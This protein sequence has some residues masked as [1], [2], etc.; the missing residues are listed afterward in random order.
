[1]SSKWF[2][3]AHA[4]QTTMRSGTGVAPRYDLAEPLLDDREQLLERARLLEPMGDA[5]K[6]LEPN[7]AGSGRR[8]ALSVLERDDVVGF[9][10]HDEQRPGELSHGGEHVD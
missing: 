5:R 2:A 4:W 10:V 9:A 6:R 1:M 7:V 3:V 8:D